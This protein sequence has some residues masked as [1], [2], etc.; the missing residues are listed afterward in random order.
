[1]DEPRWLDPEELEAWRY[2]T[3][4]LLLLPPNLDD[5]LAPHGVSFFEYSIMAGL[6][7]SPDRTMRMSTLAFVCNG[8]LS[9]LSHAVKRLEGRGWVSR[10]PASDD[11][12]VTLA[13]L[14]DRGQ[15][16]MQETAPTHVES[17]RS[18]VFDELSDEQ[19]EQLRD[20]GAALTRR[21]YADGPPWIHAES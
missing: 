19:V 16:F 4:V 15:R 6:S 9:R 17:V 12:R 10:C 13:T 11:R 7:S 21:L 18:L 3:G 20:I 5:A 8:S 2:L 14:T 1:M